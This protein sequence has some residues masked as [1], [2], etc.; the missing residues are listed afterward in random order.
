MSATEILPVSG[1]ASSMRSGYPAARL[2]SPLPITTPATIADAIGLM[3]GRTPPF[4][5]PTLRLD[6]SDPHLHE[7]FERG[8]RNPAWVWHDG[9]DLIAAWGPAGSSIPWLVDF[10]DV[11]THDAGVRLLQRAGQDAI[12]LGA[13]EF[14]VNLFVPASDDPVNGEGSDLVKMAEAAGFR[15]VVARRMFE[16]GEGFVPPP[17]SLRFEA[18]TDPEDER[19]LEVH[20]DFMVGSLDAHDQLAIETMGIEEAAERMYRDELA[21]TPIEGFHLVTAGDELIGLAVGRVRGGRGVA[22]HFGVSH[23]HR[24]HGYGA[25]MLGFITQWLLDRGATTIIGATDNANTPM[26]AAFE[27]V[28]YRQSESRIDLT[29]PMG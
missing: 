11:G 20:R 25:Q 10:I 18:A 17:T 26:A 19:L 24:G 7:S 4:D 8:T 9:R 23:R 12:G 1:N 6:F 29:L 15:F 21:S 5:I 14:E 2:G 27:R 16:L 13:E 28:G 22:A 3:S